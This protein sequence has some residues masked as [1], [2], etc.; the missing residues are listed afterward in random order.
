[1][2]QRIR[3]AGKADWKAISKISSISGYMDYI[4]E[5][6]E[7]YLDAGQVLVF[8][9]ESVEGFLKMEELP[10]KSMWLSGAR[11]DPEY[12]RRGIADTLTEAAEIIARMRS[13]STVRLF[14]YSENTPSV[15]LAEKRGY[16]V[17]GK[18]RFFDGSIDTTDL[19]DSMVVENTLINVGWRFMKSVTGVNGM[20]K[21]L[22]R[23]EGILFTYDSD[24]SR[25]YQPISGRFEIVAGEGVT[26]VSEKLWDQYSDV[27][28]M[29]GFEEALIFEKPLK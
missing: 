1:M 11:V 13:L 27:K 3:I 15:R 19:D 17:S 10:D 26:C 29:D 25:F 24:Y 6:G 28:L 14:I 23:D 22:A 18:F 16:S 9:E 2:R 21:F 12:R 8:E 5:V 4:N 7:S 20:G